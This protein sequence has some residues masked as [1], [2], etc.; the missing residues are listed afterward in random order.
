MK[1][2]CEKHIDILEEVIKESDMLQSEVKKTLKK[3][4]RTELGPE[5]PLK[6]SSEK[7]IYRSEATK[8]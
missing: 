8:T 4:P 5:W 3:V 6:S 1:Y 2:F 7:W